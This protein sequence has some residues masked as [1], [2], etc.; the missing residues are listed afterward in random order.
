M[1]CAKH[2]DHNVVTAALETLQQLLQSLPKKLLCK[3]LSDE[4]LT[5]IS[6]QDGSGLYQ[7]SIC[8]GIF[9]LN[10]N[11]L[12][13]LGKIESSQCCGFHNTNW[14]SDDFENKVEI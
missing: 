11:H 9:F 2:S 6:T 3:L 12:A 10:T 7:L 14:L 13:A 8:F 5:P 4:G 1:H